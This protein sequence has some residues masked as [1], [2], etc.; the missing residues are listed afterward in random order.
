MKKPAGNSSTNKDAAES[1]PK[2]VAKTPKNPEKRVFGVS[3]RGKKN[4][5]FT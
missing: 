2:K 4:P 1:K 3:R 5:F